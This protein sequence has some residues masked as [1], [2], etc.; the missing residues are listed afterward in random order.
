MRVVTWNVNSMSARLDFVLDFIVAREPD[1]LCVQE[2]K[3]SDEAFPHLAFAQAGFTALTHGQNQWN[4]V[5]VLVRK[6]VDPEPRIVSVGLPGF[7]AQGARLITV[8][9]AGFSVT[10]AYVPNGKMLA[11]ADY[12]M[13]LAWLDGLATYVEKNI[14]VTKPA[15]IGG[16][17]NIVPEDID[18]WDAARMTGQ[19]FH[20]DAERAPLKRILGLGF[21][22]LFRNKNPELQTFSWWDYR[23]GA[24]HRRQGLRIDLLLGSPSTVDRVTG[25]RIDRD[26]RKK[27]EGRIPSDHAPVIIEID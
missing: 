5:G 2:L 22:D 24:F 15:L 4:G 23:A 12:K 16:D 11:H 10:S 21:V 7:E 8:E 25:T 13:K 14:D 1:I 6:S 20:T 27:R 26:F 3:L 19:I 9:A 18:S 17:F